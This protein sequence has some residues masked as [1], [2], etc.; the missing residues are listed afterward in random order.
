V[1]SARL[2]HIPRDNKGET[3]ALRAPHGTFGKFS[4]ILA[5][6]LTSIYGITT[7]QKNAKAKSQSMRANKR[8]AKRKAWHK[9]QRKR[10]NG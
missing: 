7:M 10:A 5:T 6:R 9:R 1:A 8:K 2:P 4:A 3:A